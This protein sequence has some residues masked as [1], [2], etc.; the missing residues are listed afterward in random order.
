LAPIDLA[1]AACFIH[2][3][4][5]G[6]TLVMIFH[7]RSKYTVSFNSIQSYFITD[8]AFFSKAIGRK[9]IVHFFWFYVLISLLAFFL[10]SGIL[11][12]SHV[13]YPWFTAAYTGLVI[14]T[15]GC[16]LLN[17]F[18]GFQFIEDGKHIMIYTPYWAK[19][20]AS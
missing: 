13:I 12:P 1:Q 10:D 3:V 20:I 11:P 15:Y 19:F 2:G 4:A 7:I 14:M 6:M 16:L 17:G 9:E 8:N 18:V 5:I